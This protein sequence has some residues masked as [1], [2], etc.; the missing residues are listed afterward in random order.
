MQHILDTTQKSPFDKPKDSYS[1]HFKMA[2]ASGLE[3]I[4]KFAASW[5]AQEEEKIFSSQGHKD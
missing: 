3:I 4:W 1:K 5:R 2:P